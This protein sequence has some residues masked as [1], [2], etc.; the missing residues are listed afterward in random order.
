MK[1]K[2]QTPNTGHFCKTLKT[3]NEKKEKSKE[4]SNT[5]KQR[6]GREKS[7]KKASVPLV[8]GGDDVFFSLF[9]ISLFFF[10]KKNKEIKNTKNKGTEK[11]L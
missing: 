3:R 6:R 2:K 9:F 5:L 4:K 10:T 7:V 1:K 8:F 11:T